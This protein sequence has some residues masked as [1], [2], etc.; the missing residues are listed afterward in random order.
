MLLTWKHGHQFWI[1]AKG[2]LPKGTKTVT[3]TN[4]FRLTNPSRRDVITVPGCTPTSNGT[5]A[6]IAYTVVRFRADNPGVWLFHCHLQFHLKAGLAMV[7]VESA[8]VLQQKMLNGRGSDMQQL[9]VDSQ[10]M[11]VDG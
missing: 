2:L 10:A 5:C 3:N 6:D 1:L 4:A 8:S 9:C 11:A 7:F